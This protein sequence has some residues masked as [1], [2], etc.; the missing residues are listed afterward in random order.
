M[1]S[2]WLSKVKRKEG[3]KST[4]S[5]VQPWTPASKSWVDLVN[6]HFASWCLTKVGKAIDFFIQLFE[7]ISWW[8]V[9]FSGCFQSPSI[10][11]L[12]IDTYLSEFCSFAGPHLL[13][14]NLSPPI[15]LTFKA[16]LMV[17]VGLLPGNFISTLAFVSGCVSSRRSCDLANLC[18]CDD[19]HVG[20]IW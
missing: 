15:H 19:G 17:K 14:R 2:G 1:I 9:Y 6:L 13:L 11:S 20:K 10:P 12:A 4:D 16:T 7:S 5:W 3:N 8:L 18:P